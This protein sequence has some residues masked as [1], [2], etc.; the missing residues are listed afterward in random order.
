MSWFNVHGP[1]DSL[2]DSPQENEML[3]SLNFAIYVINQRLAPLGLNLEVDVQQKIVDLTSSRH[4]LL[5]KEVEESTDWSYLRENTD[6]EP[7]IIGG[8][9]YFAIRDHDGAV[10]WTA[11]N[12]KNR[13]A[14]DCPSNFLDYYP[15]LPQVVR[16]AMNHRVGFTDRG[17]W[18]EWFMQEY[19]VLG[20]TRGKKVWKYMEKAT[21]DFVISLTSMNQNQ[22]FTKRP[23]C[24][25]EN[26]G[27]GGGFVHEGVYRTT[28]ARSPDCDPRNRRWT[29]EVKQHFFRE[30]AR[31]PLLIAPSLVSMHIGIE[32]L[33][34]Y[35]IR[36][37]LVALYVSRVLA[38]YLRDEPGIELDEEQILQLVDPWNM[39][40]N[41]LKNNLDQLGYSYDIRTVKRDPLEAVK[42]LGIGQ[43]AYW[44]Q[45]DKK[46]WADILELGG[47]TDDEPFINAFEVDEWDVSELEIDHPV[48]GKISEIFVHFPF[49]FSA[50]ELIPYKEEIMRGYLAY[51]MNTFNLKINNQHYRNQWSSEFDY[52]PYQPDQVIRSNE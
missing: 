38:Q 5:R 43:C 15:N 3:K 30:F 21:V 14:F 29:F 17:D 34:Q 20:D 37:P 44:D 35:G 46:Y 31:I 51:R 11:G 26:D 33:Q 25:I 12:Y 24:A 23:I 50:S 16:D 36:F 10:L 19:A 1:V 49:E 6:S 18:E 48:H 4:P 22:S 52:I 9:G 8:H 7:L 28:R 13:P 40:W 2:L 42:K 27:W 41:Q 45:G 39:S 47:V 32:A